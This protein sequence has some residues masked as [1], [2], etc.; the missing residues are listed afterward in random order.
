M[1]RRFVAIVANTLGTHTRVAAIVGKTFRTS[2]CTYL[3]TTWASLRRGQVDSTID[4]G[5]PFRSL[6]GQCQVTTS[7]LGDPFD[8]VGAGKRIS[9]I[10]IARQLK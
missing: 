2:H 9:L 8:L 3:S 6:Q 7:E 10:E 1:Q 5:Q 4:V